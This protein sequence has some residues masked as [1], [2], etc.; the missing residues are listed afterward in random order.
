MTPEQADAM[1]FADTAAGLRRFTYHGMLQAAE[2]LDQF[3]P[4]GGFKTISDIAHALHR[5]S[6]EFQ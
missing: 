3:A 2:R 4:E 6:R 1:A 5:W